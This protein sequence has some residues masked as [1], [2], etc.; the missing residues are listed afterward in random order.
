[1]AGHGVNLWQAKE[2]IAMQL[3]I[4]IKIKLFSYL[5]GGFIEMVI[6]LTDHLTYTAGVWHCE[7]KQNNN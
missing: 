1:M 4:D 6:V 7:K 5:L 2:Y 3:I